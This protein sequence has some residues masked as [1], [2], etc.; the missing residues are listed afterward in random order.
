MFVNKAEGLIRLKGKTRLKV[1]RL[2]TEGKKG[3]TRLKTEGKK[4]EGKKAE[5]WMKTFHISF[6]CSITF[7]TS[8][9]LVSVNPV[10]CY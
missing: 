8:S 10:C 9:R 7:I 4:A 3:K 6:S 1:G 2:K 5:E